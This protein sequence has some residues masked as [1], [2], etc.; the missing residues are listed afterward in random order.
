LEVVV[1]NTYTISVHCYM[2]RWLTT[3][4]TKVK[5]KVKVIV[6]VKFF[7]WPAMKAQ[8]IREAHHYLPPTEF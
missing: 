8:V 6:N 4:I 2:F 7:V 5:E 1:K 3:I